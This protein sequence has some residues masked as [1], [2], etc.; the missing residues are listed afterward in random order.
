MSMICY[1]NGAFVPHR[2]VKLYADDIGFTRGYSIYECLRTY[3]PELFYLESHMKRLKRGTDLLELPNIS[4]IIPSILNELIDRNPPGD[5]LFRIYYSGD[6]TLIIFAE[7]VP[8]A[9]E[10]S[11]KEGISVITTK[12]K[13]MFPEIKTTHY[14]GAYLALK[15][16]ERKGA[17]DAIYL[18]EEGALLETTKGNFFALVGNTLLTA[19]D[20]VLHG[21]TREVVLEIGPKCGLKIVQGAIPNQL[22]SQFDGAFLTSTSKEILP[23]SKIDDKAIPLSPKVSNLHEAFKIKINSLSLIV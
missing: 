4:T 5:L 11:Y 22:I 23:I 8:Q 9:P 14:I 15:E 7:P 18:D 10:S 16:A 3:G 21:I 17:V 20:R 2:E 6:K 19:C 12:H 1:V 13:R